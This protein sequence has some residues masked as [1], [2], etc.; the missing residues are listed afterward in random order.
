MSRDFVESVRLQ[1]GDSGQRQLLRTATALDFDLPA[2]MS[3]VEGIGPFD[4]DSERAL[5]ERHVVDVVVT[6]NSGGSATVAKLTLAR[7]Q[8]LPVFLLRRPQLVAADVEFSSV[9]ECFSYVAAHTG[10][11]A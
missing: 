10:V 9:D 3:W 7:E 11:T 8:G 4:I 6:K 1:A 5:F 2:S